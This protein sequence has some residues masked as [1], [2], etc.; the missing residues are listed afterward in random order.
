MRLTLALAAVGNTPVILPNSNRTIT[1][2]DDKA[3]YGARHLIETFFARVKPYRAIAA[4]DD[5]TA[6]NFLAA[7]VIWL[8]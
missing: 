5:H 1:R 8:N 2:D 6:R 3:L 4:H 7:S